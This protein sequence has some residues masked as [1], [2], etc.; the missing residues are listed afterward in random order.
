VIAS[1]PPLSKEENYNQKSGPEYNRKTSISDPKA[2]AFFPS[3]FLSSSEKPVAA[4]SDWQLS[5]AQTEES[6]KQDHQS[7]LG[8]EKFCSQLRWERCTV[9]KDRCLYVPPSCQKS[10]GNGICMKDREAR[11]Q[12]ACIACVHTGSL[13]LQKDVAPGGPSTICV[14]L[15][16]R[17]YHCHPSVIAPG[18]S[19]IAWFPT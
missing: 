3:P 1:G 7:L 6:S 2:V 14:H 12:E 5:R 13:S 10:S 19:I 17:S 11:D 9:E 4:K 15:G 18:V 16:I 8:A